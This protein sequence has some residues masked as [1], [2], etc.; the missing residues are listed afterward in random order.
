MVYKKKKIHEEF[1]AL[2]EEFEV[3]YEEFDLKSLIKIFTLKPMGSDKIC[4]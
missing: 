4:T 3:L 1:E 2:H